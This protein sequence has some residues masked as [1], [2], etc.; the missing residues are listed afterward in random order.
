MKELDYGR[1]YQY[2]HDVEG[3]KVAAMECLP[4]SLAGRTYYKPTH[5]G[6]EKLLA[7]RLD[8]IRRIRQGREAEPD[9]A[10]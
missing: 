1:D 9:P 2:A 7:A 4:A 3:G 5:E 6:R 8:D 10:V